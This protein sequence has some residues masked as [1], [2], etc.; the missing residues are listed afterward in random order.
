MDH[1]QVGQ[2]GAEQP[3]VRGP[4][5][6]DVLGPPRD[7]QPAHAVRDPGRPEPHL[8]VVE[9]SVDLAEHRLVGHHAAVEQ[10]LGVPT[11]QAVV[12]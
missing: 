2:S 1:A 5:H 3:P 12:E 10:D 4:G 7:S 6:G 9:P 8:G 11:E